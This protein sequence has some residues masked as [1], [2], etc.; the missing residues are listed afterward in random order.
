MNAQLKA[1]Q[2]ER[3]YLNTMVFSLT[4][5]QNLP[6]TVTIGDLD[7]PDSVKSK[8]RWGMTNYITM[9]LREIHEA[10]AELKKKESNA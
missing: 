9:R 5:N 6:F 8:A 2:D 1:L 7:L 4:T 10:I 3:D